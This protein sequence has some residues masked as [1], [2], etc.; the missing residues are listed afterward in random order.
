[1]KIRVGLGIFKCVILKRLGDLIVNAILAILNNQTNICLHK[2]ELRG[3]YDLSFRNN[4]I[5][6]F[7]LKIII[8]IY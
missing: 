2:Y 6:S 1:M 4:D 8:L 3:F 5:D 7:I